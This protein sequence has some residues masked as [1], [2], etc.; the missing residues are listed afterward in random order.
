VLLEE[1]GGDATGG[2]WWSL[3]ADRALQMLGH[4]SFLGS[5]GS[6]FVVLHRSCFFGCKAYNTHG[7]LL[8]AGVL[9]RTKYG[10]TVP[11]RAGDAH[12][13]LEVL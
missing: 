9:D 4:A 13:A 1:E 11:A 3:R 6:S 10:E 7:M 5:A 2:V 8:R 12:A